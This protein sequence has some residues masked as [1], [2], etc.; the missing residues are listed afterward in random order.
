MTISTAERVR[1]AKA[2]LSIRFSQADVARMLGVAPIT[3]KQYAVE[4][5]RPAHRPIPNER[6]A[7]LLSLAMNE[8]GDLADEL[9]PEE[10][11]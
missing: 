7:L 10:K 11:E 6:L 2:I 1:L 8:L 3:L 9:D 5:G 4:A